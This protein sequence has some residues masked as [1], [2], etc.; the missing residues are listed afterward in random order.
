M[1]R[2]LTLLILIASPVAISALLASLGFFVHAIGRGFGSHRPPTAIIIATLGLA[3]LHAGYYL[4]P[5][6]WHLKRQTLALW[7]MTPVAIVATLLIAAMILRLLP[8]ASESTSNARWFYGMFAAS[9]IAIAAYLAPII[10]L[11]ASS[12]Q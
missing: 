9:V 5:I 6:L 4:G 11:T 2:A 3:L 10:T 7:L 12:R 1:S 8:A